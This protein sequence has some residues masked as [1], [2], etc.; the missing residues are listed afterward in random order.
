MAKRNEIF[1]SKYLKAGDLAGKSLA[2]NR[3]RAT[4]RRLETQQR[5][6]WVGATPAG[7]TEITHGRSQEARQMAFWTGP[8]GLRCAWRD[9]QADYS[10][11]RRASCPV[12]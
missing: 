3:G 1:P 7:S 10:A 6:V 4:G 9:A 11:R 8:S 12:S 5:G 2:G